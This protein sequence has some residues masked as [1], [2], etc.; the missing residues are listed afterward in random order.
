GSDRVVLVAADVGPADIAELDGSVAA[1]ALGAGGPTAHAAIVARSLGLPMVVGLGDE[2]DG[3]ATGTPMLVDGDRGRAVAAP[4]PPEVEA[5]EWERDRRAEAERRA[6][7]D[8]D[9]PAVTR[10]GHPVRVLANVAG[11]AEVDV[12]LAAGA[13]GVGLLRT[14]L[15]FLDAGA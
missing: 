12:A 6:R 2:L 7:A 5:A 11:R 1:V 3:V 4:R 8:R 10:D 9:L 14:E 13:E 15:A